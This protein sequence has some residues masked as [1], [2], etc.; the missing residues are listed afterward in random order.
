MVVDRNVF[1]ASNQTGTAKAKDVLNI[2]NHLFRFIMAD[3]HS[4][5]LLRRYSCIARKTKV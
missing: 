5:T 2:E 3:N 4:L 1:S